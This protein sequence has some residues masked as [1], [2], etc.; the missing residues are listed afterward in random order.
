[1]AE[2]RVTDPLIINSL[3]ALQRGQERLSEDIGN[4]RSELRLA[5]TS[6]ITV[7]HEA[8]DNRL[9][10]HSAYINRM[11]GAVAIVSFLIGLFGVERFLWK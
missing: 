1:M 5:L 11:I 2:R 3:E 4:L 7:S 9:S 10:A 6:H 8:M